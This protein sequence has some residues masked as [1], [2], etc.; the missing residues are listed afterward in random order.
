[1]MKLG[2]AATM[3]KQ[4]FPCHSRWEN[5]CRDQKKARQNCSNVKVMTIFCFII[6]YEFVPCGETVNKEFYLNILK[7]LREAVQ[8]KRPEAWTNMWMLHRDSSPAHTSFL[9]CEFLTK[10][11]S[12]V[13]PL[14]P[15]SPDL[16]PADFFLLVKLKC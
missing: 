10:H 6:H 14:P 4:K 3:L 2:C 12:I 11:E 13:A 15:Y 1:M 16:G 5:C 7:H 9:I 8:R